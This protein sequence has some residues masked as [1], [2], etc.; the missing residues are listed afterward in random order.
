MRRNGRDLHRDRP[1]PR[2]DGTSPQFVQ[3]SRERYALLVRET[4][5]CLKDRELTG[6]RQIQSELRR[7]VYSAPAAETSLADSKTRDGAHPSHEDGWSLQSKVT[8]GR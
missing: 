6:G 4:P 5:A 8:P 2:R 1:D 3:D 7:P